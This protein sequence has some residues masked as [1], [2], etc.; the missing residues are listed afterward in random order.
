MQ[1]SWSK[2][3]KELYSANSNENLW[4]NLSLLLMVKRNFH[5]HLLIQDQTPLIMAADFGNTIITK[6]I[7]S[8]SKDRVWVKNG[9]GKSAIELAS[10]N[11]HIGIVKLLLT[12]NIPY[13]ENSNAL[14]NAAMNGH[15][16]IVKIL[17]LHTRQPNRPNENGM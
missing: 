5:I 14:L 12:V 11:G 9:H 16:K 15:A 13:L 2:F 8:H 3:L 10:K 1:K 6:Y 4:E 17:A 7:V